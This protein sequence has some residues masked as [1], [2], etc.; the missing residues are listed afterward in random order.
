V[1]NEESNTSGVPPWLEGIEGEALPALI[2]NNSK[3]IRVVAGPGSGKTTGLKRRVQRLVQGDNVPAEKIFVGTFTRAIAHDLAEALG[4]KVTTDEALEEQ[5]KSVNVSTLH[6]H[7][8][9]LIRAHPTSRPGRTLR[10]LLDYEK[11][12][13]LYDIGQAIDILPN[14]SDRQNELKK[15]CAAWAEGTNL[16]LAGFVGE[17][18]RWLRRHG[19]MLIDEVVN[20]AR[21]ALESGDIPGGEFDHVII[22]E[23]QDLTAAEQ[24]LVEEIWSKS[25]SLVVLG[26]DDQSIY[27]FRYNHPGGISEFVDRWDKTAL[28]DLGIPE[29]RRCGKII[30]DL[31]NAMMAEAGSKKPPMISK[32][33]EDGEVS[34]IYWPSLGNEISGL[35][36]FIC[37]RKD[38]RFLVL[39]PRRF[40]GY[41][42]KK[43]IGSDA[44]TSFHEEVLEIPLVQQRFTLAGICAN[45]NDRVAMRTL[46]GFHAKGIKHGPKRNAKGYESI[47]DSA[48]EG[49]ALLEALADG[50]LKVF[51]EG[52][53]NIR[54]QA[55]QALPLLKP[56]SDANTIID[57]LFD[58]DLSNAIPEKE[59]R[60]KAKEDL[61]HLRDSAR[62]LYELSQDK[63]LEKILDELRYKISMRIPLTEPHEARV[64]IMTHF[65]AKGL[66][67]DAVIIASAADQIIPGY[68]NTTQTK[69]EEQRRLLYV[70]VTRAKKELVVSWPQ[71]MKYKDA[72][73]NQV[74]IDGGVV[75]VG[76]QKRVKLGRSKLLP[77][78]PQK[79]Q[80]GA[81][82]LKKP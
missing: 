37:E 5:S 35:A 76:S 49:L 52:S 19:G 29:N 80:T 56:A 28:A 22:D 57:A 54:A 74:R 18:D 65:G 24:H 73:D 9:R 51:G 45:P 77:D 15:V 7:A 62:H 44:L 67:A 6:S 70:S 61:E 16:E 3:V 34:L 64:H 42:L 26:D 71:T 30:V 59:K 58:P 50:T 38:S 81:S 40:I 41:R 2:T 10:F 11:E 27:S 1:N 33:G 43:A 55:Q 32:R 12:V 17:M 31:G 82:W 48:L 79:P 21:V 23:Y 53:G 8:L 25:G 69:R 4:V 60:E 47:Q 13:M 78:I 72:T 75:T 63:S 39:V 14:Q 66:E 36:H 20:L 68:S 46:L